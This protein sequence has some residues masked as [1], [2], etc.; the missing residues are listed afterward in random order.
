MVKN[1]PIIQLFQDLWI[2]LSSRRRKQSGLL[3]IL[4]LF[5]SFAEVISI[6]AVLPFL[7][8]LVAPEK[9]F[10]N[11]FIQPII[12]I[13]EISEPSQLILPLTIIFALAVIIASTMRVFLL[14]VTTRLSFAMGADFSILIYRLQLYQPYSE[15]CIRNSSDVI[16]GI[17]NK[18]DNVIFATIIP[19]LTILNSIFVML[20]IFTVLVIVD[21]V[22]AITV[23]GSCSIVYGVIIFIKRK[24]LMEDSNLIARETSNRI[25]AL[26]E[27]LG[28]IRDVLIDG[29]QSTYCNIYRKSDLSLRYA[30]GTNIIIGATPRYLMEAVGM[31]LIALLAYFLAQRP[32]GVSSAIPILGA[33]ALGAQRLLPAMQLSYQSWTSIRGGQAS[34]QDALELLGQ[35]LP[36]Y[37]NKPDPLPIVFNNNIK[38]KQVDFRYRKELPFVLQHINLEIKK[39][40]IVGVIGPTGSGK[41]TLIDIIMGLLEPSN[42]TMEIDGDA[43]NNQNNRSWQVHIAHVPQ[44]IYLADTSIEENIAFGQPK[45]NINFDRVRIVAEQ[46]Q[47]SNAINS[48]PKQYQTRVGERG[49]QLSGGQ[50]QRIGIARALYKN[51][52]VIIFD[53]A[54]SSLDSET[55]SSVMQ[56]IESLGNNVT[57]II[58]AHRLSTLKNC[59]Q[60]IELDENGIKKIGS[61]NEVI[62]ESR[63][64]S[65]DVK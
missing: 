20:T 31:V 39:G 16:S 6:G 65:N 36:E 1:R 46:A 52:D 10:E 2:H 43:I 44:A 14:W 59:S 9:I 13:L 30:Q 11:E 42:G 62:N 7:G 63:D 37:A 40:S 27:G 18:T 49:V 21:S 17:Q 35:S 4:M 54:T 45:E 51:A 56:S 24:H 22:I 32:E 41:S 48:W 15:Q 38:L 12:Q 34:L 29:S 3:L 55:E 19:F 8:V 60:I 61:Y 53:E 50:R 23:F 5:G 26:Q 33:L 25:N 64:L 58:I 57:M 28:G 47:I